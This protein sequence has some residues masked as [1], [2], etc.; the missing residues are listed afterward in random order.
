MT[1]LILCLLNFFT[2]IKHC[3]VS[4]LLSALLEEDLDAGTSSDGY[5]LPCLPTQVPTSAVDETVDPMP[6]D[7][8][9]IVTNW[10][11]NFQVEPD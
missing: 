5:D 9:G 8:F 2:I 11:K 10:S 1:V 7:D 6:D 4:Y 3:T